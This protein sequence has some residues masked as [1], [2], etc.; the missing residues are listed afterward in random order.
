MLV[1]NA[2]TVLN[3]MEM[4]SPL[5]A[6]TREHHTPV[7]QHVDVPGIIP[8]DDS[9]QMLENRLQYTRLKFMQ[10]IHHELGVDSKTQMQKT[11]DESVLSGMRTV[12][13]ASC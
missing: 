4:G 12:N 5:F 10:N 3:L 6:E 9:E 7:I 13:K 8:M 2:G 1:P 11:F